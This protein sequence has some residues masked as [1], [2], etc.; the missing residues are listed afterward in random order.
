MK[1]DDIIFAK[2][3]LYF[4]FAFENQAPK[5]ACPHKGHTFSMNIIII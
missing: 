4:I 1:D 3:C 2:I 5:K